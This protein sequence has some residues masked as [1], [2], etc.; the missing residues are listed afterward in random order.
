M[1][2]AP[3]DRQR[4]RRLQASKFSAEGFMGSDTRTVEEI[5]AEDGRVLEVAGVTRDDVAKAMR[6][7]YDAARDALGSPVHVGGRIYC[8]SREGAVFVLAA[9]GTYELL[10]RNPLGELSFATPAVAGGRMY[11][12]TFHHLI[13]IGRFS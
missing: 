9:A 4:H 8:I 6:R 1:K 11:L 12:R 13:S 7:I 10:A 5:V 2:Q 3:S